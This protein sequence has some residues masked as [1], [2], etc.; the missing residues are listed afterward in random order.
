MK[1]LKLISKNNVNEAI[2]VYDIQVKDEHHY[3]LENGLLSHNSM[4][5]FSPSEISGGGGLKYNASIILNLG[6]GKLKR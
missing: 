1:K 3:F 6:K 5:M 4:S 2:D